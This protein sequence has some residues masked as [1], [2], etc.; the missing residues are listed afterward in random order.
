MSVYILIAIRYEERDLRGL[1]GNDYRR[2]SRGVG[3]LTPRFK[4]RARKQR[5]PTARRKGL[6]ARAWPASPPNSATSATGS[7]ISTI[8]CIRHRRGLFALIDE[9][10]TA[11]I[12]RLLDCDP[13]EAR[14]VQKDHFH[15]HGTTLAG[16]MKHHESTRTISWR[17]STTSRS[18]GFERNER[19]RRRA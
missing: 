13:D 1:F 4:R 15:T 16:L 12:Q 9:R 18:T 5:L 14:R 8:A 11:Y 3:M 10:M 6:G 2:L 17:T 19:A 7:S